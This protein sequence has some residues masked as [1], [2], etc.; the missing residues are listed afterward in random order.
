MEETEYHPGISS[1]IIGDLP[2]SAKLV[3]ITLRYEGKLTQKELTKETMLPERTTRYA[4]NELVEAGVVSAHINF[5]DA[6]Q[7]IYVLDSDSQKSD[8]E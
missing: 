7:R 1:Q 3:Y 6:R 5:R 8:I 4:L 2:P